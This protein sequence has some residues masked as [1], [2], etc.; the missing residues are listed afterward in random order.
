MRRIL[1]FIILAAIFLAVH[2]PVTVSAFVPINSYA[3]ILIHQSTGTV[4]Y[5]Q[6][7]HARMYPAGL[8]KMLTAIIALEYLHPQDIII[9]G[10]EINHVPSGAIR[11][12]HQ[13]GEH[14][15]VHNLLRAL[16]IQNGNDSG[17]IL[18]LQTVQTERNHGNV[19]YMSAQQIFAD[20]MNERARSLG[21]NNTNF[22]NPNG[23]HHDN[24]FTTAYD[25]ALIAQ[26][27]ME[28]PL[29]AEIAA[30]T[31]FVGN[32][33]YG[34]LGDIEA[35]AD[36]RT[37][38]YHWVNTNELMSGGTFHYAYARGI[39]SGAT[40]QSSDCLAAAAYRRGVRLIA[41]VLDSPD[42][43][44]W[45]DARMLFDHGFSNYEY[46]VVVEAGQHL[47]T[48]II[49]N[50]MLGSTNIMDV[51]AGADFSALLSHAQIA[52]LERSVVFYDIFL[53]N[54]ERDDYGTLTLQAPIEANEP[55]GTITYSLDGQIIFQTEI[56]AAA[57]VAERSLDSDMDYYLAFIRDNIFSIR[58]LPLWM[59]SAGVLVGILGISLAIAERRRSKRSSWYGK[60]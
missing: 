51:L 58:A 16:M 9:V 15:T 5:A 44:R 30:M 43:G 6:N 59:G 24:H 21:A 22:E 10:P 48:V 25:M 3:A 36:V 35:F 49:A 37:I 34:Y 4:L 13:V 45:Q 29:L 46:H 31:E 33:L 12:G 23:L 32:S 55:L 54:E 26:A 38:D 42:P 40:P 27:F 53:L 14:I 19:P 56:K 39:R 60:R 50:A 8:T 7:E 11:A 1:S 18:A 52:R 2:K 41:I 17:V 47:E 28:N 20:M 57:S